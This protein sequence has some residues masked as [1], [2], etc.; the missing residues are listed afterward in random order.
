MGIAKIDIPARSI[1]YSV[2]AASSGERVIVSLAASAQSG[3]QDESVWVFVNEV[4]VYEF[5]RVRS[6][7]SHT[8]FAVFVFTKD[9]DAQ[10]LPNIQS[11]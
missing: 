9:S 11:K 6:I 3:A 1:V 10:H 2:G 5:M 4:C 8:L 7:I